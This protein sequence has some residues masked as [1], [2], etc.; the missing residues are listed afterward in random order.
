MKR[1]ENSILNDIFRK[2]YAAFQG[3]P[4]VDNLLVLHSIEGMFLKLKIQL[5]ENKPFNENCLLRL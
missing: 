3:Y 1:S 5:E 2:L 4:L